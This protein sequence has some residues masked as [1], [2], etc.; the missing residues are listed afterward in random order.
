MPDNSHILQNCYRH[1][2]KSRHLHL[3]RPKCT[4][5]LDA[6]RSETSSGPIFQCWLILPLHAAQRWAFQPPSAVVPVCLWV[7]PALPR[8]VSTPCTEHDDSRTWTS[9]VCC[10]E[11]WSHLFAS[12]DGCQPPLAPS[13]AIL[14]S[15]CNSDCSIMTSKHNL[16]QKSSSEP[17]MQ[18]WFPNNQ[19]ILANFG[20]CL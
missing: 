4:A 13:L 16:G 10:K 6:P 1:S 20:P 15:Q 19:K 17:C 18:Q 9:S 12:L 5:E 8:Q 3:S 11:R 7:M 14:T 2:T